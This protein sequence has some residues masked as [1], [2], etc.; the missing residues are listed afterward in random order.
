MQAMITYLRT[1][2]RGYGWPNKLILGIIPPLAFF[3]E[4]KNRFLLS[5]LHALVD[6]RVFDEVTLDFLLP[7]HTGWTVL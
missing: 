4:N 7:G 3:R 1:G 6:L 2:N 5:F